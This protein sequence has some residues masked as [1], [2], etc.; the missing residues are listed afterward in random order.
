MVTCF[1]VTMSFSIAFAE[2]K[3]VQTVNSDDPITVSRPNSQNYNVSNMKNDGAGLNAASPVNVED[4]HISSSPSIINMNEKRKSARSSARASEFSFTGT[5]KTEGKF[6]WVYPISLANG[7][8]VQAMMECPNNPNLDYDLYL[9]EYDAEAGNVT[10]NPLAISAYKTYFNTYPGGVS[11]TLEESLGYVNVSGEQKNYAIGVYSKTGSS[12]TD[13]FKLHIS[14]DYP[15]SN[16]DG[17]IKWPYELKESQ[18]AFNVFG[19]I[20]TNSTVSNGKVNSLNDN[21]WYQINTPKDFHMYA[22]YLNIDLFT[23]TA[24]SETKNAE[25]DVELYYT[26]DG[27]SMILIPGYSGSYLVGSN[28]LGSN[29]IY[30]IRVKPS[31]T[32]SGYT[33]YKLRTSHSEL[34]ADK[35]VITGLNSIAGSNNYEELVPWGKGYWLPYNGDWI[36]V[37]G[38]LANEY[39]VQVNN[40]DYKGYVLKA[41]WS[42]DGWPK[43]PED[44]IIFGYKMGETSIGEKGTFEVEIKNIPPADGVHVNQGSVYVSTFDIATIDLWLKDVPSISG[45]VNHYH[46]ADAY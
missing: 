22:E 19:T 2:N 13:E 30:Y 7:Q 40:N 6:A 15:R 25:C 5:I 23:N 21:D 28:G 42:S 32:F 45:R 17:T 36:K 31:S 44:D 3:S 33:E 14:L 27:Q 46:G 38:Y 20:N 1:F 41:K 10:G 8:I 9:S 39:N 11:K 4:K 16:G 43:L 29:G 18:N 34:P 35:L 37:K 24:D 26:N 12:E